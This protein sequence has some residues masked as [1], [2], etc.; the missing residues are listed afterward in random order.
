MSEAGH[1]PPVA[2]EDPAT[3]LNTGFL[4]PT[5]TDVTLHQQ[6][7]FSPSIFLRR[8][9]D[10]A[11]TSPLGTADRSS[12][13]ASVLATS[14]SSEGEYPASASDSA[15]TSSSFSTSTPIKENTQSSSSSALVGRTPSQSSV[16]GHHTKDE[17]RS[18]VHVHVGVQ[19]S[20]VCL[21]GN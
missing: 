20:L 17:V 8:P 4:S 12:M 6:L 9:P 13:S 21:C 11:S 1:R 7:T 2:T 10:T 16:W 3:H 15:G 19:P 14:P 5:S 18:L